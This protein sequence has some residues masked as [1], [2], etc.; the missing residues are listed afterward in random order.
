MIHVFLPTDVFILLIFAMMIIFV[1]QTAAT[2]LRVLV[3]SL[4]SIVM[5]IALVQLIPAMKL[6]VL[7]SML[8]SFVMM[9]INVP[10][11]HVHP[12]PDVILF[13]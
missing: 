7:A 6:V 8:I 4:L 10:L 9:V 1:L 13:L 3:F 12:S 11:M 2:L 5:T